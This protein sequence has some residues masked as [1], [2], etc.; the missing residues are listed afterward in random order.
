MLTLVLETTA[1]IKS[2][3]GLRGRQ[4]VSRFSMRKKGKVTV[5]GGC[6]SAVGNNVK[7]SMLMKTGNCVVSSVCIYKSIGAIISVGDLLVFCEFK[8]GL[9]M[10]W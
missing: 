10:P 5:S 8:Y 3:S 6:S 7:A 9:V 4:L 2:S 1:H